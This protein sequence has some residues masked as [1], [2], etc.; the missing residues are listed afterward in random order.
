MVEHLALQM[1]A[2]ARWRPEK[3]TALLRRFKSLKS[4]TI[5]CNPGRLDRFGSKL[6]RTP[7]GYRDPKL[8]ADQKQRTEWY[9]LDNWRYI[10]PGD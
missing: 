2:F 4:L 9:V 3:I 5:I 1:L 8:T 10:R 7:H 6:V